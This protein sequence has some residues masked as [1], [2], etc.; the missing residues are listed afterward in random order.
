MASDK[1]RQEELRC[2][3]IQMDGDKLIQFG[4]AQLLAQLPD[5]NG[6]HGVVVDTLLQSA[7]DDNMG[8]ERLI[9]G[10]VSAMSLLS[11]NE[12]VLVVERIRMEYDIPEGA[13]SA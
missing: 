3:L 9:A 10:L 2:H 4:L 13:T 11:H 8:V 1:E 7:T 5:A 6:L 12:R